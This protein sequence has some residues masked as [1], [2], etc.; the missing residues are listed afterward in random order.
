MENRVERLVAFAERQYEGFW[1][2]QTEWILIRNYAL[3]RQFANGNVIGLTICRRFIYMFDLLYYFGDNRGRCIWRV[4][5]WLV[6]LIQKF[7]LFSDFQRNRGT[8]NLW[9]ICVFFGFFGSTCSA[10]GPKCFHI[11]E[12]WIILYIFSEKK[13]PFWV[14]KVWIPTNWRKT[15]KNEEFLTYS[16]HAT[17]HKPKVAFFSLKQLI[18]F[19]IIFIEV[20]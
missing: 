17:C 12:F 11:Y 6:F 16:L 20:S 18:D 8:Q 14:L 5:W 15:A 7:W 13:Y 4:I 19:W 3:I 1:W 2:A 10:T 9:K